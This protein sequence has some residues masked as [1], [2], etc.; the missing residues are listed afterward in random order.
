[1]VAMQ[2]SGIIHSLK[3][4]GSMFI[5]GYSK[6]PGKDRQW[7]LVGSGAYQNTY[8]DRRWGILL[9]YYRQWGMA[10]KRHWEMKNWRMKDNDE[11]MKNFG[12]W[13][14]VWKD[15]WHWWTMGN[16]RQWQV[17]KTIG[18]YHVKRQWEITYN[19]ELQTMVDE[20]LLVAMQD[21][22]L[23]YWEW[24]TMEDERHC[25]DN[26]EWQA[27]VDENP[28]MKIYQK[29]H[30]LGNDNTMVNAR[31]WIMSFIL[32]GRDFSS[33]MY[34]MPE[35]NNHCLSH[36][37]YCSGISQSQVC[38]CSN[39]S[40]IVLPFCWFSLVMTMITWLLLCSGHD[41]VFVCWMLRKNVQQHD[42]IVGIPG[43]KSDFRLLLW[44]RNHQN[45]VR[46][47]I[48]IKESL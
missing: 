45:E 35:H 29:P 18:N 12:I 14:T 25:L 20:S 4:W 7:E 43:F 36:H 28:E 32:S 23:V 1:M 48:H 47:C 10:K 24:Q 2:H 44:K 15:N 33:I 11:W 27:V 13:Q 34:R 19:R 16:G 31:L 42:G 38:L 26:W 39:H 22:V 8:N 5:T 6:T 21:P 46:Y 41:T 40:A 9:E 3:H 37:T 17:K 30:T